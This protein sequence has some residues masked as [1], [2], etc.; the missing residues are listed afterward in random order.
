MTRCL[1]YSLLLCLASWLLF[2]ARAQSPSSVPSVF[3][4]APQQDFKPEEGADFPLFNDAFYAHQLFLLGEAHGVQK[5]QEVDFALLQHLN[6]KTGLRYYVAEVDDSKAYFLNQYLQTGQDSLLT[7]VFRSWVRGNSQWA[8][9]EFQQKIRRIR[10]LNLTL[11]QARRIQFLGID[12]VQDLALA[13]DYLRILLGRQRRAGF[14][15]AGLD[16]L[17]VWLRQEGSRAELTRAARRGLRALPAPG[18]PLHS[19]RGADYEALQHLLTNLSYLDGGPGRERVLYLN[20][21]AQ[22]KSRGLEQEK[23]YGMWGV[24]HVLQGELEGASPRFAAQVKQSSLG[25][26]SKVVSIMC[27]FVDCRMLFPSA[28]LPAAWQQP[29]S[30]YSST[31]KFNH[32]GP[33]VTIAGL[34]ELTAR[35]APGSLTLFRLDAPGAASRQQPIAV[36]YAPAVPR[37]Q[38]LR[39]LPSVPAASYVQYLLLVRNSGPVQPLRP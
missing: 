26:S 30:A 22:L 21:E 17:V 6:A 19:H 18:K 29:N 11:P 10:Q 5:P 12:E 28:G 4:S 20:F 2:D 23:F 8:N 37:S 27:A 24:A 16:S 34:E 31:D 9:Q 39:F 35:T 25:L 7:L 1:L 33:L 13:G 3:A 36:R 14:N 32:N 38:Q 15:R